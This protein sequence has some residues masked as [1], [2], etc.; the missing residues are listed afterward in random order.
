ML[1]A[2][3]LNV[4]AESW[5]RFLVNSLIDATVVLFAVSILWLLIHKKASAQ[6]GYSLFLLVLVKLLIPI[7]ITVPQV[8]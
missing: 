8:I 7:E 6:L 3:T 5:T 4:W 2:S 1:T